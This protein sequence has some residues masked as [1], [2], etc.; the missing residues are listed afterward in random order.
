M[1]AQA[2]AA[3]AARQTRELPPKK[4]AGAG[5]A[6]NPATAA[7]QEGGE[8][9]VM[10]IGTGTAILIIGVIGFMIMSKGFRYVV[11]CCAGGFVFIVAWVNHVENVRYEE[12]QT[13]LKADYCAHLA[14]FKD[15]SW[16]FLDDPVGP[17]ARFKPA[18]CPQRKDQ[19]RAPGRNTTEQPCT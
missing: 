4:S 1:A 7:A 5:A 13:Q 16:S 8:V 19:A 9:R 14:K 10:E 2:G 17:Y 3:G 11:A 15:S 12:R 18:D 6:R